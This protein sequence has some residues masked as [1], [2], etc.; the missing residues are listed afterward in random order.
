MRSPRRS[1]AS[2][3]ACGVRLL[4]SSVPKHWVGARG[5]LLQMPRCGAVDGGHR[6]PAAL[7]TKSSSRCLTTLVRPVFAP[8][9]SERQGKK[10]VTP[11]H[12]VAALRELGFADFLEEVQA[13]WHQ[14]REDAQASGFCAALFFRP[15]IWHYSMWLGREQ[16][17]ARTAAGTV[18]ERSA[19]VADS[20]L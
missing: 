1:V 9:V 11:E 17:T 19:G 14:A 6:P 12:V 5:R 8:Q 10:T 16:P 3:T 18:F 15:S 13:H 20:V 7:F 2:I 4:M